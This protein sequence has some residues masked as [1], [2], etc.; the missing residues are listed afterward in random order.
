MRQ[1]RSKDSPEPLRPDEIDGELP[2]PGYA[3]VDGMMTVSIAV[4]ADREVDGNLSN[5]LEDEE[6]LYELIDDEIKMKENV[7]YG[8]YALSRD[9]QSSPE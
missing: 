3:T 7:A 4:F 1:S 9:Q 6:H 5:G 2:D 8:H